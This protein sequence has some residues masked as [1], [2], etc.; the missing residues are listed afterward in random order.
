[1]PKCLKVYLI[2]LSVAYCV[3]CCKFGWLSER[4]IAKDVMG[5]GYGLTL[6]ITPER[7]EK[8]SEN[9]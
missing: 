5:R 2:T 1:M 8:Y 9:T 7:T 4:R 6:C 3:Q